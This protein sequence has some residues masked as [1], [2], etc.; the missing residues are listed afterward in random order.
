M[1]EDYRAGAGIDVEIDAA[2]RATGRR[3]ACPILALWSRTDLGRWH[4]VLA[5]WRRWAD[6][7]RAM[8]GHALEAGRYLAE[9]GPN[10]VADALR[11]FFTGG[12]A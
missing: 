3:I 12:A 4:D 5:V 8:S 6:D 2:D 9:E 7:P 11:A 1:C 10:E